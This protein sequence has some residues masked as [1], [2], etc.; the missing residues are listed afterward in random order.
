[1]I[2]TKDLKDG[3]K[4]HIWTVHTCHCGCESEGGPVKRTAIFKN[5]LFQAVKT[6]E[7]FGSSVIRYKKII[8]KK[9][10]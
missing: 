1:M 2:S 10:D 6:F 7:V 3:D 9:D 8:S 5:G 4:Y